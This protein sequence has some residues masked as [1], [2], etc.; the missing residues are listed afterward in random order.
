[1]QHMLHARYKVDLSRANNAIDSFRATNAIERYACRGVHGALVEL[2][3]CKSA[4]HTAVEVTGGNSLFNIVVDNDD[5]ATRIVE[6]LS[7]EKLGRATFLPLNR[8]RPPDVNYPEH[9]GSDAVS[10]LKLLKFN[11]KF[12]PAMRQVCTTTGLFMLWSDK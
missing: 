7:R 6:I 1:M 3:S 11:P 4:L 2:L 12:E 9:Y 5:I 10:M 8:I